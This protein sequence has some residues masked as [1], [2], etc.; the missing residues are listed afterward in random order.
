MNINFKDNKLP[1][2]LENSGI[3]KFNNR[4]FSVTHALLYYTDILMLTSIWR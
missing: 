4:D 1:S 3:Q 2:P